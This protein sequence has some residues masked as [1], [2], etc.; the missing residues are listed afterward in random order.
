MLI[1]SNK[2]NKISFEDAGKLFKI[3]S[4]IKNIRNISRRKFYKKNPKFLLSLNCDRDVSFLDSSSINTFFI[5]GLRK[6]KLEKNLLISLNKAEIFNY[7][8]GKF[9]S[10]YDLS[11]I[12]QAGFIFFTIFNNNFFSCKFSF[13]IYTF[14]FQF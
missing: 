1:F 2:K 4:R 10:D 8:F 6:K 12:K 7:N 9:L 5:L 3:I 11:I 14:W 13:S